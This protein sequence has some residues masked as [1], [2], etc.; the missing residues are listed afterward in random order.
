[1]GLMSLT[2]ERWVEKTKKMLIRKHEEFV[3]KLEKNEKRLR[4]LARSD[5]KSSITAGI[6]DHSAMVK[7]IEGRSKKL[8][9]CLIKIDRALKDLKEGKYGICQECGEPISPERLKI[10][11]FT[12]YCIRCK[13][14]I[15]AK[16]KKKKRLFQPSIAYA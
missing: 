2:D 14:K 10:Q 4:D 9:K 13:Q 15:E 7:G 12:E 1:M 5:E 11:P 6:P 16:E 3:E 8:Q